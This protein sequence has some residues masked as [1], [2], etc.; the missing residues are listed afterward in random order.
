M[1]K[2]KM[3]IDDFKNNISLTKRMSDDEVINGLCFLVD[4][5]VFTLSMINFLFVDEVYNEV[6]KRVTKNVGTENSKNI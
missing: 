5:H 4:N 3:S 2:P 6:Q 1:K